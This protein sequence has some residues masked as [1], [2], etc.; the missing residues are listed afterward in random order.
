VTPDIRA[1][2]TWQ[3]MIVLIMAY[4]PV[5][6]GSGVAEFGLATLFAPFVPSH[7]LGVFIVAWRFFTY[8]IPLTLGGLLTLVKKK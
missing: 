1:A 2:F 7:I 3:V 5:P 6:G 4:V 8:Y